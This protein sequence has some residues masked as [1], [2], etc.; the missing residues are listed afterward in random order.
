M[1]RIWSI[2]ALVAVATASW[3]QAQTPL[4]FVA[5]VN[6]ETIPQSELEAV[7]KVRPAAVTPT[8]AA[9][10][11]AEAEQIVQGLVDELLMRQFLTKHTPAPKAEE[12]EQQWSALMDALKAQKKSLAEYCKETQQTEKQ[13]RGN[14]EVIL[15]WNTYVADK[16]TEGDMKGYY[17]DNKDYFDRVTIKCSHIVLRVPANAPPT[18]RAEAV[19]KL[20]ELRLQIESGQLKF[21]DAAQKYSQCPSAP[22]GG[23]LGYIYRKWMVEEPFAKAAFALKVNEISDVVTTDFGVHLILCTDRKPPEPSEYAKVKDDVRECC[24]EEMRLKLLSDLRKSAK[25]EINLP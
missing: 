8:T 7:L 10:R 21:E 12:I 20:Q 1:R 2:S 16:R 17:K 3:L 18:E 15:R 13:I 4:K 11:K 24:G 22:K 9:H 25:I 6:G 23:N 5:V 19:K 14:I